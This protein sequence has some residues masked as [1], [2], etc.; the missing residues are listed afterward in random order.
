MYDVEFHALLK[1]CINFMEKLWRAEEFRAEQNVSAGIWLKNSCF[2][3]EL[4]VV[5]HE[6]MLFKMYRCNFVIDK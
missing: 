4:L 3:R 6:N 1:I 2:L 5:E